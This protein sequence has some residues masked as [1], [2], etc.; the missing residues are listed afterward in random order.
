MDKLNLLVENLKKVLEKPVDIRVY[1][2]KLNSN[3]LDSHILNKR[4]RKTKYAVIIRLGNESYN[5][6]GESGYQIYAP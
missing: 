5:I 2:Y 6:I 1:N 3:D 4:C